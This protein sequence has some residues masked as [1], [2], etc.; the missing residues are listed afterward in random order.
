MRLRSARVLLFLVAFAAAAPATA[1]AAQGSPFDEF[2]DGPFLARASGPD[3]ALMISDSKDPVDVNES[4][5]Y[6]LSVD[7]PG[8]G[9]ASNP[10]VTD[11]ISD[12]LIVGTLPVGCT[13]PNSTTVIC[14]VSEIGNGGHTDWV[15]PVTPQLAGTYS[16][17]GELTNDNPDPDTS[18][19]SDTETTQVGPPTHGPR[20][21][22]VST[23]G[24]G[25]GTVTSSPAGISCGADCDETYDDGT[26]VTLTATPTS[27]DTFGGWGADCLGASGD[28][29]TVTMSET[30]TATATFNAAAPPDPNPPPEPRFVTLDSAHTDSSEERETVLD[31]RASANVQ[32]YQWNVTGNA[33]PDVECPADQ[34]VLGLSSAAGGKRN[35]QLSGLNESGES[36]AGPSTTTTLASYVGEPRYYLNVPDIAVCARNEAIF[37]QAVLPTCEQATVNW[38]IMA[39]KGCF[40][41]SIQEGDI[42]KPE[43]DVSRQH[44]TYGVFTDEVRIICNR[45]ARGE[46]PQSKCDNAKNY[47][48]SNVKL[49][50]YVSKGKVSLN[51]VEIT[52]S[53]GASVVVFPALERVISSKATMRWG[54]FKI[55][56]GAQP[57]DLNLHKVTGPIN[58]G[59]LDPSG[60]SPTGKS[61]PLFEFDASKLPDIGGFTIDGRV[62]LALEGVQGKRRSTATLELRAPKELSLFG[63]KPPSAQVEVRASTEFGPQFEDLDVQI[64]EAFI[65]PVHFTDVR[66]RYKLNGGISFDGAG[67]QRCFRKEWEAQAAVYIAGGK[68]NPDGSVGN[69][70]FILK[71]PP[72]ENGLGFCAGEFTHAGGALVF[73]GAIPPPQLFPGLFL[74]EINFGIRLNPFLVR[75]GGQVSVG[76]IAKVRGTLLV[77]Y[78]S[79]GKPFVLSRE[80]AGAELAQLAGRRF[81]STTIAGGGAVSMNVPGFG[82]L[83]IGN[84]AVYYSFPDYFGGNAYIS[85]IVPGMRVFGGGG[86]EASV[87]TKKFQAGF[88]GGACLAGVQDGLCFGAFGN[89]TSKGVVACLDIGVHPGAG[90]KWGQVIPQIWLIDGCKPSE[91]WVDVRAAKARAAG[92]EDGLTFNLAK[93]EDV[94]NIRLAGAGGAPMVRITTPDGKTLDVGGQN[95]AQNGG[96]AG[97]RET[98]GGV[99]Y[100]GVKDGVPGTYRITRMPGSPAFGALSATRPG[101]DTNFTAKVTGSGKQ[102]TLAYDARKPG[103]QEVTFFEKGRNVRHQLGTVKGGPGK[104]RFTPAV[105]PAGKRTIVAEA[106]VDGVPI[107]P[108]T[109]TSFR[110]AGTPR[111]GRPGRVRVTRHRKTLTIRWGRAVGAK[112][113][114]VVV[115]QGKLERRF[116]VKAPRRKLTVGGVALTDDGVVRVSA[117]GV[118]QDWGPAR[119]SNHFKALAK[120]PSVLQTA[121]HNQRLE[122]RA[123]NRKGRKHH[124]R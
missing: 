83:P 97:L 76:E 91:Y 25:T 33:E 103:H 115:D 90:L 30:K 16:N 26:A 82:Q 75:G 62:S 57:I 46:I 79:P 100:L 40:I 117:Q 10:T 42:P 29:C 2:G 45:A 22:T 104:L 15:I 55:P 28:T 121:R 95:L 24:S 106:T 37:A 120:A 48:S 20:T 44:Y 59:G 51:G 52:P 101:Y 81:D 70:G 7:N 68:P 118:L 53:G 35:I 116:R 34:G 56:G 27:G 12:D 111:T 92:N 50:F 102:R 72:S 107:P 112:T 71:P 119:T 14:T 85:L 19:N 108:Q 32:T 36:V 23:T 11:T 114:G 80:D 113:Y 63:G 98:E 78:A 61:A 4:F 3:L 41:H 17:H 88:A 69:T 123:A 8:P 67:N 86:I 18:N 49:D 105:G 64:P 6:T 13:H 77:A 60:N 58:F 5:D 94:K 124:H 84:A 93:G 43:L 65:G 66:F 74:D 54:D 89:V 122:D 21:L 47:A 39:A 1:S 31:A 38:L 73:G 110:W 87:R 9:G 96:L 109:L 99:T